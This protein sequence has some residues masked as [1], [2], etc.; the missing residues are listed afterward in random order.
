VNLLSRRFKFSAILLNDCFRGQ[1]F[2]P[3]LMDRLKLVLDF[4]LI[5]LA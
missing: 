5:R 1:W 4:P 2:G 3:G